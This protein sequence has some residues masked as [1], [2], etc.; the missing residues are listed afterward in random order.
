M[1]DGERDGHRLALHHFRCEHL[2]LERHLR[3]VAHRERRLQRL[4]TDDGEEW[5]A[6]H[7]YRL[8][9]L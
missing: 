5:L 2:D 1:F 7:E 6:G 4:Q 8:T 3:R 9:Q